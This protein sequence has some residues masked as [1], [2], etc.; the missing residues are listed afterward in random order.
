M[1]P[2]TER[3]P[4]N[5]GRV[6]RRLAAWVAIGVPLLL[7][8]A[9]AA[10]AEARYLARAGLEE[11]RI[12]VK[13]RSLAALVA[14]PRTPAALRRRFELVLAARAFARDSLGL[15]VGDTYTTYADVGRDTLLVVLSAAPRD[16]LREYTWRYPI[17]AAFPTRGSST[18]A[19]RGARRPSSSARVTTPTCGRRP[20]SPRSV[21]SPTRSSRRPS[22]ATPWSSRRR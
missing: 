14:D 22:G 18:R 17:V 13:R 2:V 10:S 8:A 4:P 15:V 11:A 1:A 20:R 9:L 19:R 5:W 21:I 7:G 6:V 16:R 12:L 3:R